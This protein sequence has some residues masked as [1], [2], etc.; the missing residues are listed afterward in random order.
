M[1]ETT[2]QR[3][4]EETAVLMRDLLMAGHDVSALRPRAQHL[5]QRLEDYMAEFT[6]ANGTAIPCRVSRSWYLLDLA[7]EHRTLLRA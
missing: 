3:L 5:R 7:M 1:D 4:R 2:A 6:R